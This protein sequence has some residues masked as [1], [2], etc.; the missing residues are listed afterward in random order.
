MSYTRVEPRLP[1]GE[2]GFEPP[3]PCPQSRCAT[4][5]RHSPKPPRLRRAH[6]AAPN[7]G[8]GLRIPC[9]EA[10]KCPGILNVPRMSSLTTTVETLEDNKVRLKIAVPA[11]EFEKAIDAAFRKLAREV[12]MPGFRPGKAPR[13]LL[14]ARLGSGV[15]REQALRDALPEYYA[16]AVQAEDID[17]IAPPEI[18]ITAGE[19]DGDVEFDAVVEVRPVV[20]VSGYEA[21]TVEVAEPG[22][23]RRGDR[24][25]DRR[26]ARALRR[27]RGL[28]E[29]ARPTATTRRST[30]R[31][32]ST[33][34]RSTR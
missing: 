25:A 24:R 4:E 28:I 26:A 31:A 9:E 29:P 20:E 16:D 32:R 17:V 6:A 15:A 22:G 33:A 21:L 5:L 13:Q 8:V 14:E 10:V 1:V 34:S 19:E 27:P 23:R 7:R 30:S 12:K 18:D 11:Q 3:T 2:G